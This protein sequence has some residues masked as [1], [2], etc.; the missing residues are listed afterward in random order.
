MSRPWSW[1]FVF[2]VVESASAGALAGGTAGASLDDCIGWGVGGGGVGDGVQTLQPLS[3]SQ[4][5]VELSAG[6]LLMFVREKARGGA[7]RAFLPD[8]EL[9]SVQVRALIQP[10]TSIFRARPL[11]LSNSMAS[12]L[13]CS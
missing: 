2:H 7:D 4:F 6:S 1:E 8:I 3:Y 13:F 12:N 5:C 11:Q 9:F 10:Q